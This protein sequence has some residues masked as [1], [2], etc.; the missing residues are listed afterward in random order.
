M[1][2]FRFP[3]CVPFYLAFFRVISC[4]RYELFIKQFV[5]LSSFNKRTIEILVSC[6]TCF[7]VTGVLIDRTE[8]TSPKKV[9][10]C[11]CML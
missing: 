2:I 7:F 10:G 6:F 9:N 3:V 5:G 8:D 4:H 1:A 11:I